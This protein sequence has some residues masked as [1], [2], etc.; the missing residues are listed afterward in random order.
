MTELYSLPQIIGTR[1]EQAR[2]RAAALFGKLTDKLVFVDP[3]EAELAKLFTNVW[4]Y[5]QFAAVN[6]FYMIANESR[7]RLL[8]HPPGDSE[9]YPSRGHAQPGFAAGPCLFKDTMQLAR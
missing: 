2:S 4:R 8:A 6:Q 1:N 9:D 3:E 5:I 7:P